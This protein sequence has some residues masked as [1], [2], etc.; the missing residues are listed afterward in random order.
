MSR[1]SAEGG[2]GVLRAAYDEGRKGTRDKEG[3]E[4]ERREYQPQGE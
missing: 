4:R 1:R 2:A 3:E